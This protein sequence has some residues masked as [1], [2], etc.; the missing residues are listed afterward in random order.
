MYFKNFRISLNGNHITAEA[1]LFDS[2]SIY[3]WLVLGEYMHVDRERSRDIC[4][5]LLTEDCL[6]NSVF[7]VKR[8]EK[9]GPS[10]AGTYVFVMRNG[11]C[12]DFF[13]SALDSVSPFS[14]LQTGYY[15]ATSCGTF[16]KGPWKNPEFPSHHCLEL[17]HQA[18]RTMKR[19]IYSDYAKKEL[20]KEDLI[21]GFRA[22]EMLMEGSMIFVY[23]FISS[24]DKDG[25]F[26]EYYREFSSSGF[27]L[28]MA[29]RYPDH[30]YRHLLLDERR[31]WIGLKDGDLFYASG[32]VKDERLEHEYIT[33]CSI[34]EN[35]TVS[36]L[37][38]NSNRYSKYADLKGYYCLLNDN[39]VKISNP[40]YL[41]LY[42]I[43]EEAVTSYTNSVLVK[44]GRHRSRGDKNRFYDSMKGLYE[45]YFGP[46]SREK[47]D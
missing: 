43:T 8:I 41:S 34:D 20:D 37:T 40:E 26:V 22:A 27:T 29:E 18:V 4:A 46:K 42:G 25:K 19:S 36:I 33:I 35:P 2:P 45:K 17:V 44:Y 1:E 38:L 15:K 5:S 32:A 11:R 21:N 6:N 24:I 47:E 7:M 13:Y 23:D 10:E 39:P 14:N 12:T 9:D 30:T 28:N 16:Y 31:G 3:T